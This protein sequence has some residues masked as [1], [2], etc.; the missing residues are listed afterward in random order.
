MIKKK[1]EAAKGL[2]SGEVLG[3]GG[4]RAGPGANASKRILE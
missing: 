4:K 2:P 3:N 1:S